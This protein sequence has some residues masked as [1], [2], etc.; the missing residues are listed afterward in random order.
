MKNIT[1]QQQIE[2]FQEIVQIAQQ[3]LTNEQFGETIVQLL[4]ENNVRQWWEK[5]TNPTKFSKKE[6][7]VIQ[8][9]EN[10][11]RFWNIDGVIWFFMNDDHDCNGPWSKGFYTSKNIRTPSS[12]MMNKLVECGKFPENYQFKKS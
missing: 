11:W 9:V 3:E 6:L 8:A 1:Q 2:L 4:N 5:K 10:N 7:E 12:R